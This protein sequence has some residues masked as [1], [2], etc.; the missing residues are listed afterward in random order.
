ME[1]CASSHERQQ[2]ARNNILVL[3]ALRVARL[4]E[5]A[6]TLNV[7]R[8]IL[9]SEILYSLLLIYLILQAL[10]I[11]AV[12]I[13]NQAKLILLILKVLGMNKSAA[14]FGEIS[15]KALYVLEAVL[16]FSREPCVLQ[17]QM[18]TDRQ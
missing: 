5:V 2:H 14:R 15:S 8:H 9:F 1:A 16:R 11:L 3:C 4:R 17:G 18:L 10:I 13:Y 12:Q 6:H 7:V